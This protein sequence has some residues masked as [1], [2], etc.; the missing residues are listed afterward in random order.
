MITHAHDSAIFVSFMR[1]EQPEVNYR[2]QASTWC[3][4]F[5]L[6]YC[7]ALE[8][9]VTS[10]D[11]GGSRVTKIFLVPFYEDESMEGKY[12]LF[13]TRS[14]SCLFARNTLLGSKTTSTCVLLNI[15]QFMFHFVIAYLFC[16]PAHFC[17]LFSD[18][19]VNYL[20]INT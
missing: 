5:S 20:I 8:C 3:T 19:V 14:R 10:L 12:F 18:K 9:L 11:Y 16:L 4:E 2:T 17:K 1:L 15:Y 6:L 13:S 7:D